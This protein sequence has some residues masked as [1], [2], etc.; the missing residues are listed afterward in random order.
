MR[1]YL[2]QHMSARILRVQRSL[3]KH[4]R[5]IIRLSRTCVSNRTTMALWYRKGDAYLA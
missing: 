1:Y 3:S 2:V 4:H 5:H